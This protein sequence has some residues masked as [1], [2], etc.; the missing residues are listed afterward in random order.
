MFGQLLFSVLSD[1]F[2]LHRILSFLYLIVALLQNLLA[3]RHVLLWLLCC[4]TLFGDPIDELGKPTVFFSLLDC[5]V[6][7]C[8]GANY[9]ARPSL[10]ANLNVEASL[11]SASLILLLNQQELRFPVRLVH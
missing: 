8:L 3:L 1:L 6:Y 7:V 5:V 10:A 2:D 11:L 4:A 9:E